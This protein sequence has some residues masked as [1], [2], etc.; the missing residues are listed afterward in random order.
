MSANNHA[1]ISRR[2]RES[3]VI[4]KARLTPREAS[5]PWRIAGSARAGYYLKNDHTGVYLNL[6]HSDREKAIDQL[7]R[8]NADHIRQKKAGK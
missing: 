7:R 3:E 6:Q 4:E 5:L 8:A 1:T 2:D